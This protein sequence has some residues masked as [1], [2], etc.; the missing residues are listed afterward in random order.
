MISF[1]FEQESYSE[2]FNLSQIKNWLKVVVS[3][4]QKVEGDLQF[5]VCSDEYLHKINLKFLDHDTFT[6]IVSFPTSNDPNIISGDIFLSIERII[7][8]SRNIDTDPKKELHRVI[9]HGVLHFIG[10]NDGTQHEKTTM[11]AKEDYYLNL[12]R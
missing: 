10:Y 2:Y 5:I 9:V 4:E 1:S 3:S 6:D 11:R 12:L 7:D 8:N